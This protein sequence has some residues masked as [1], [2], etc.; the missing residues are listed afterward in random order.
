MTGARGSGIVL[1]NL[2]DLDHPDDLRLLEQA[3]Q[4]LAPHGLLPVLAPGTHGWLDLL[5]QAEP[6]AA[7]IGTPVTDE[8]THA[9]LEDR[10]R[11]GHR[12][13][14]AHP[15]RPSPLLDSLHDGP[16]HGVC[17]ALEFLLA[18]DRRLGCLASFEHY[19][20]H[21][22]GRLSRFSPFARAV[23]SGRVEGPVIVLHDGTRTD[24]RR[25]AAELLDSGTTSVLCTSRCGGEAI[26]DEAS[27]RGLS[28][29]EDLLV[30]AGGRAVAECPSPHFPVAVS[31]ASCD[32]IVDVLVGL[33]IGTRTP[34]RD[35]AQSWL[36]A[37]V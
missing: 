10:A 23:A 37:E 35:H 5:T 32:L 1:L 29:P 28:I 12:L 16:T 30:A 33:A 20:A 18:R 31:T 6:E 27:A 19:Q 2:P 34:G 3:G 22:Q 25:A 7:Y 14:V 4:A 21:G 11:A 17:T 8:A 13:L 24:M 9:A 15:Y 26:H 36:V